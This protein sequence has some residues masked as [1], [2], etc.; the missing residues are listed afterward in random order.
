M[1][2]MEAAVSVLSDGLALQSGGDDDAVLH[3]V[4]NPDPE[5]LNL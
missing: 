5:T 3:E 4:A 1:G 2:N